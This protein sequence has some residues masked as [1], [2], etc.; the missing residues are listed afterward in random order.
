MARDFP[1]AMVSHWLAVAEEAEASLWCFFFPFL[2]W[3]VMVHNL[4]SLRRSGSGEQFGKG[5]LIW[6]RCTISSLWSSCYHS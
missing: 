3:R 5:V 1:L 2:F 4:A 6:Q